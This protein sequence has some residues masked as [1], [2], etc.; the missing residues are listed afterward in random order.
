MKEANFKQLA[1]NNN[2]CANFKCA[3]VQMEGKRN[4]EQ[5]QYKNMRMLEV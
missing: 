2:E 4:N 1:M 5:L 3:S